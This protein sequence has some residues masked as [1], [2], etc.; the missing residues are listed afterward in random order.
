MP[1]DR[2]RH[3]GENVILSTTGRRLLALAAV[4]SLA[5][6]ACAGGASPSPSAAPTSPPSSDAPASDEPTAE[7][8]AL[9]TDA[10]ETTD[11]TIGL[12]VQEPIQYAGVLAAQAGIYEKYGL[13]VEYAFFE[14]DARVA[15]ALQAGQI[16]I[17]LSGGSSA[18][19]SQLTDAPYDAVGVMG[20]FLT[21]DLVCQAGIDTADDVRGQTVAISTF[22]GT[23]HAAAL[24][25]LQTLELGSADAT[26][27]QIGGQGAR[28]AAVQGGSVAC[29][30]VDTNLRAQMEEQGLSIAASVFESKAPFARSAM[31]ALETFI[32]ANP[33]TML[34]VVASVI[35]AQNLLFEDPAGQAELYAEWSTH[36]LET[37]T[38]LLEGLSEYANHNLIWTRE[39]FLNAQKAIATVNPDIIEVEP[40]DA[41]RTDFVDTLA[42]NGFYEL[43]GVPLP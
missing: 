19:S 28:I 22:G 38:E 23:S 16:Q 36:D 5:V 13:N 29:A 41:Y 25:A 21:D 24:L 43:I 11:I 15:A 2:K 18:I 10:L 39:A 4:A 1:E 6:G 26:I 37:A 35:E 12:S 33:N 8:G 30:V 42:A 17:G 20:A 14:G 7:P 34:V 27:T 9:P 32:D 3:G 31:S 40:E